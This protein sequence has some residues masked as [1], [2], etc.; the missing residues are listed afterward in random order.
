VFFFFSSPLC[1]GGGCEWQRHIHP[2]GSNEPLD[3]E[4]FFY[5]Y[6][7]L[8]EKKILEPFEII[9]LNTLALRSQILTDLNPLEKILGAATV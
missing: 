2:R 4:I 8:P 6:L 1:E 3:L 9:F 7:N 5:R